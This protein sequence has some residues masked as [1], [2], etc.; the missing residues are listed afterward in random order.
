MIISRAERLD[1]IK[2]KQ[3]GIANQANNTASNKNVFQR[4]ADYVKNK[5]IPSKPNQNDID[6]SDISGLKKF[7]EDLVTATVQPAIVQ[8]FQDV[9]PKMVDEV[10]RKYNIAEVDKQRAERKVRN[11]EMKDEDLTLEDLLVKYGRIADTPK[12]RA[13]IK[14]EAMR[15]P[16]KFEALRQEILKGNNKV[17]FAE[18]RL[19]HINANLPKTREQEIEEISNDIQKGSFNKSMKV[20]STGKNASPDENFAVAY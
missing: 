5:F 18:K 6:F 20:L 4:G 11:F 7:I 13:N 19:Q 3:A 17:E 2:A 15:Y 9:Y 10:N 14:A 12:H 8:V 16:D 1:A